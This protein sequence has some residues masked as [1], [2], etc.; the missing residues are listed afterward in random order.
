[1]NP[2][3]LAYGT[4][5]GFVALFV[6]G[7]LLYELL[8]GNFYA[9]NMGSTGMNAEP[10]M[11]KLT[12]SNVVYAF[13]LAYVFSKWAGIKTL[14]AGATSG[15]ILGL[16][17]GIYIDLGMSAW[18]SGYSTTLLLVDPIVAAAWTACGGAAVGFALGKAD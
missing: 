15:A 14:Q 6:A 10:D 13:F 9:A 3:S 8:L 2:K 11:V 4:V 5:A 1:M 12:L 18:M 7:Y 16:M 17:I